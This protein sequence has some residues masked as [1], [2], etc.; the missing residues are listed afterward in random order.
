MLHWVTQN[1]GHT[2]SWILPGHGLDRLRA[3]GVGLATAATLA[4]IVAGGL[5]PRAAAAEAKMSVGYVIDASGSTSE[6]GGPCGDPNA[7]GQA[8]TILDCEIA[9]VIAFNES[10][11]P[12]TSFPVGIVGFGDDATEADM[13]PAVG[14]QSLTTAAADLD[15][16]GTSDVEEVA[17]SLTPGAF[18]EF[19]ALAIDGGGTNFDAALSEL[20]ALAALADDPMRAAFIS[21]AA[22]VSPFSTGPGSPLQATADSGTSVDTFS[23]GPNSAGCGFSSPLLQI[24]ATTGGE[25]TEVLDGSQLTQLTWFPP[26]CEGQPAT[27]VG[28]A[29]TDNLD[30]TGAADVVTALADSDK[31]LARAG[32]DLVCGG[33]GND[34]LKGGPGRDTLIGGPGN[35]VCLGGP[36]RDKIRSC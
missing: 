25:C 22:G 8:D 29:G 19:T 21:D 35:D 17:K 9:G 30:G 6:P 33:P 36:G 15:N 34:R 16:D 7:D 14:F 31:V 5:A 28:T 12:Y 23:V 2:R 10:V 1:R 13:S 18:N 3:L 27:V 4:H 32:N 11:K 20:N 26:P 24:A